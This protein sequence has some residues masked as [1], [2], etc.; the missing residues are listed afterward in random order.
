MNPSAYRQSPTIGQGIELGRCNAGH[1]GADPTAPGG[2][3][4]AMNAGVR[5]VGRIVEVT[6]LEQFDLLVERGARRMEGWRLL[7]VDLRDRTAAFV[8]LDP[9]AALCS[10]AIWSTTPT[11]T[12]GA[13]GPCCSR[14]CRMRRSISTAR[15]CT[16]RPTLRPA[17]RRWVGLSGQPRRSRAM[18]GRSD[19]RSR[20][21][22]PWLGPSTMLLSRPHSTGR[23]RSAAGRGHGRSRPGPRRR[24]I[25][26]GGEARPSADPRRIRGRHRWR[27]GRDGGR[28]PR[29]VPRPPPPMTRWTRRSPCWPRCRR[30]TRP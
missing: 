18:P 20:R 26:G 9:S 14:R 13:V 25:P 28:R 7:D 12:C 30:S 6:D 23:S 16:R 11:S 21:S 8:D 29:R 5:R 19:R 2:H 3:D 17:G 1:H 22:T 4:L 24:R 10:G 27:T 15:G